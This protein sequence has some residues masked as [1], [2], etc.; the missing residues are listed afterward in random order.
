MID[1]YQLVESI[2]SRIEECAWKGW[3]KHLNWGAGSWWRECD[4][5]G[6]RAMN[7]ETGITIILRRR[8]GEKFIE[9][10][11]GDRRQPVYRPATVYQVE[12]GDPERVFGGPAALF[13]EEHLFME[14]DADEQPDVS[15][16]GIRWLLATLLG[17]PETQDDEAMFQRELETLFALLEQV[18]DF[19]YARKRG[20][21]P[22]IDEFEAVI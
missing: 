7:R 15:G 13:S 3:R 5:V 20:V 21:R 8:R 17:K 12:I 10:A 18:A 14:D 9:Y 11:D 19:D 16:G 4:I 2:G 1:I 22:T 6:F